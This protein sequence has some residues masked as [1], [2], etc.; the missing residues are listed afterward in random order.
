MD[1][2]LYLVDT[3]DLSDFTSLKSDNAVSALESGKAV[4]MPSYFFQ[5]P[6]IDEMLSDTILDGRHKN[7]SFDIKTGRLGGFQKKHRNN[8]LS[9]QLRSFMQEY[10]QFSKKIIDIIFPQYSEQ[11]RWGRT[12]YRPAEI[13][14]RRL[15]KRKDDT[16]LHVDSF[17]ATPVNSYRILRIFCNINPYGVP[18]VW[19]IGESFEQVIERF[20][21][22]LPT[23]NFK[24]AQ[25]LQMLKIT[26]SLRSA[27][28]HYQLH[29]HDAMKRDDHYQST[30]K[31]HR[32]EFPAS[33][34]WVVFTDHVSHAAHSGQFLLEQ[35]FYL[36]VSAMVKPELAPLHYWTQ[37][38]NIQADLVT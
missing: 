26:K 6:V 14:G 9:A 2:K 1:E 10:A 27:Y 25:I 3:H 13:K 31:K 20:A 16:R 8:Q 34:T 29:L 32:I 22:G 38:K 7:I 35:T 12:S 5:S 17:A 30:V 37:E 33:S 21:D 4:F 24:L 23:Y 18:R 15:S 36:P 11:V 28:D 19:D